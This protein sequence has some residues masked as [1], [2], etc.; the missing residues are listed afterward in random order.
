MVSKHRYT[1]TKG[2]R[3]IGLGHGYCGE[4]NTNVIAWYQSLGTL[5]PR[6]SW[7]SLDHFM[8]GVF[9][10][11]FGC[12]FHICD[13]IIMCYKLRGKTYTQYDVYGKCDWVVIARK[14]IYMT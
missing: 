2:L 13:C 1:T 10:V 11:M 6:S 14:I 5:I 7:T 12:V 4:I 9:H 3:D 8:C